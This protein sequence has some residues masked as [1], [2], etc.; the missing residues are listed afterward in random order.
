MDKQKPFIE[1]LLKAGNLTRN[2]AKTL[3]YHCIMTWSDASNIRPLLDL[4]GESGTGKNGIMKQMMRWC[5]SPK[6]VN[7][8]NKTSAQLRDDMADEDVVF[9]EEADKTKEPKL[10]ENWYQA[11]YDDTG[12]NLT[13]KVASQG[14]KTEVHDHYGYTILHS[15]NVFESIELDRRVLRI[16]L[17]K[18]S[19][20]PY[21]ITKDLKKKILDRIAEQVDWNMEIKHEVSNS[22][23]DV[24]LPLM[25][26]ANH[27]HDKEFLQYAKEEILQ[28]AESD[29]DTK[30]CEPKG[31]VLS[32]TADLF[33]DALRN[34][35][36][37]IAITEIRQQLYERRS[38]IILFNYPPNRRLTR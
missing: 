35:E 21:K 36:G 38:D 28:K 23:W 20:R 19:N 11:R 12:K 15:Q 10:C 13:Y 24:W 25:R 4:H 22:A 27:L 33:I 1:A 29:D 8:R 2:Q 32:E 5:S 30:V 7:A 26:V 18:N 34:R 3:L 9:I 14:F 16:T 31:I 37:H 17:F 6:W